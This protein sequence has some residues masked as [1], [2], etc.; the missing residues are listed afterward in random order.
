MRS[1]NTLGF[2]GLNKLKI[3][4]RIAYCRYDKVQILIVARSD[5]SKVAEN[6]DGFI[7]PT[8]FTGQIRP[9]TNSVTANLC[10]ASSSRSANLFRKIV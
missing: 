10:W 5:V 8:A 3:D 4:L 6:Q 9:A 2:L 7:Y 1:H